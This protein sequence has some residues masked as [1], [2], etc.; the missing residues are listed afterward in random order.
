MFNIGDIQNLKSTELRDRLVMILSG[1]AAES[2][3]FDGDC[4]TGASDD[5]NRAL[6]LAKSIVQKFAMNGLKY[7]VDEKNSNIEVKKELINAEKKADNLVKNYKDTLYTIAKEL[8]IHKTLDENSLNILIANLNYKKQRNINIPKQ[9]IMKIM[10]DFRKIRDKNVKPNIIK[11]KE[12]RRNQV[13]ILL[14]ILI[15]PNFL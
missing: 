10:D 3:V 14:F 2:Y 5:I 15:F 12:E 7:T 6:I 4:S 1:K 13:I 8:M 11:T 9:I